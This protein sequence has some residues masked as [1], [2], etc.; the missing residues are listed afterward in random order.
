MDLLRRKQFRKMTDERFPARR[1][2][3]LQWGPS[4]RGKLGVSLGLLRLPTST[5]DRSE[6][7]NFGKGGCSAV[8]SMHRPDRTRA[9][10]DADWPG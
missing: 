4:R 3:G 10:A 1:S 8:V 7:Q 6:D 9:A 2:A 5:F